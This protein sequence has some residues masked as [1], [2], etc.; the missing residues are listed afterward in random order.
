ME[1][2]HQKR[3]FTKTILTSVFA[4]LIATVIC[5]FYDIF[6]RE[7]TNYHPAD[8]INVSSLIFGV[9]LLFLVFGI[10]YYLFLSSMKK[11][12]TVFIILM[13]LLTAISMWGTLGINS[14]PTH[15]L[16]MDFR[17]LLGGTVVI[18]GLCAFALVPYLYHSK[19]FEENVI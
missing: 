8:Y 3:I 4:G 17:G 18:I 12:E 9:N 15:E 11:G 16:N 13:V 19:K 1:H 5:L 10:I 6:F 14:M 2:Y 7:S